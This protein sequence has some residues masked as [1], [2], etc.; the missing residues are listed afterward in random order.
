M[1]CARTAVSRARELA[2]GCSSSSSSRDKGLRRSVS[3]GLDSTARAQST[4]SRSRR[5]SGSGACGGPSRSTTQR[6]A[7]RCDRQAGSH[8]LRAP[9]TSAA[10]PSTAPRRS[11]VT[12][13][14][15][16]RAS[17]RRAA[18]AAARARAAGRM[19]RGTPPCRRRRAS[20]AAAR[21][22]SARAARRSRRSHRGAGRPSRVSS[23]SAA[24]VTPIP[25]LEQG[26]LLGRLVET[27]GQP[28]RVEQPPE[29]VAR[30]REMRARGGGHATRVDADEDD[31]E[32]RREHIGHVARR[33]VRF[34]HVLCVSH[35][36]PPGERGS[37]RER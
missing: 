16:R 23:G 19:R 22:R 25:S 12:W 27:G 17:S 15:G 34:G 33:R 35:L 6:T 9:G 36:V 8:V 1:S 29:V 26:E 5:R 28:R 7:S 18:P 3:P 4:R 2:S 31:A 20:R 10:A 21:A 14:E 37:L 13:T 32:V 11:R 30:I 24:F